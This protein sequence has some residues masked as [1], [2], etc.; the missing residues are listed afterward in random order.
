M[1]KKIKENQTILAIDIGNTMTS[2]ALFK[3][4]RIVAR[5]SLSTSDASKSAVLAALK[6]FRKIHPSLS[7]CI[8][9]S[10]V[11]QVLKEQKKVLEKFFS[12][13]VFVAGKDF[14]IPIKNKYLR[15]AQVGQDRLACAYAAKM[16]YRSPLIVIDFGTAMTIDVVSKKG[17]YQGG[18][19]VPGIR[20]S[21]KALAEHTALLPEISVQKP[22]VLIGRNTQESI[23]SGIFYGY[24]ALIEGI[25]K[26][27]KNELKIKLVVVL[28]GGYGHYMGK[29]LKSSIDHFDPDL[30]FS[31]LFLAFRLTQK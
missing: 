22:S 13:N 27:I 19:I 30:V 3:H 11:P 7:T 18:M 20:L 16:Q 9:C 28:T 17:E 29:F 31:G 25:V 23:L 21:L 1:K 8:I 26:K 10:V 14:N 2:F 12:G 5:K 15:P 4:D 24:V 6:H